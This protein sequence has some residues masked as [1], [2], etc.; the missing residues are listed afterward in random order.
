MAVGAGDPIGLA[1]FLRAHVELAETVELERVSVLINRVRASAIGVNPQHQV[2]QTLR[3]FGGLDDAVIVPNDTIGVDAAV[4]AGKTLL[5]AAPRSPVRT[6]LARF[7]ESRILPPEDKPLSRHE[8]RRLAERTPGWRTPGR[9][10]RR[11]ETG[12]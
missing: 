7:V 6:S 3:R 5:D 4:L 12:G 2:R 8:A 11:A 9:R 1:R 10:G